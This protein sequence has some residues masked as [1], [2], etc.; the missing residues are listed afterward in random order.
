MGSLGEILTCLN[1]WFKEMAKAIQTTQGLKI[2]QDRTHPN[3]LKQALFPQRNKQ[4]LVEETVWQMSGANFLII[5][6]VLLL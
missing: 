3:L 4:T 1:K 5:Y 6:Q 2:H